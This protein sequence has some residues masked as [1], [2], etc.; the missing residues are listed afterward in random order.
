MPTYLLTWNPKKSP[1]DA[2]SLDQG[3]MDLCAGKPFS[4]TWSAGNT[5]SIKPGD[6]VFLLRQG[7]YRPGI[8]GSG[9]SLTPAKW[10][11]HWQISKR[12]A[13]KQSLFIKVLWNQMLP[14]HELSRG[15]LLKGILPATL[16]KVASSGASI[17]QNLCKKLEVRWAVHCRSAA[18]SPSASQFLSPEEIEPEAELLEGSRNKIT[19][20]AYERNPRARAACINHYGLVC[21]VCR[22]VFERTYGSIG[23]GFIHV[24]HLRELSSIGRKYVVNPIKDL[25]PVCPNCHAMLHRRQPAFQIQELHRLLSAHRKSGSSVT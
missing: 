3:T 9:I 5:K 6:R 17:P 14:R 24:H 15:Q 22:F 12:R 18:R 20:N 21:S 11:E 1:L 8:I 23:E 25:R 10:R 19:V 13:G 16:L 4:F 2:V 7:T